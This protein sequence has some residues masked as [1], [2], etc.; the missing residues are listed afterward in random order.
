MASL[1]SRPESA[2]PLAAAICLFAASCAV[3]A[4]FADTE[5]PLPRRDAVR[6][7]A[8]EANLSYEAFQ[9][10]YAAT[11]TPVVLVGALERWPLRPGANASRDIESLCGARPLYPTCAVDGRRHG[12][13]V[14]VRSD[15]RGA[16]W[17]SMSEVPP[18]SLLTT[19]ADLMGAQASADSR[20]QYAA[21]AGP[22]RAQGSLHNGSELYLHDAPIDLLCPELLS[23]LRAPKF[24]PTDYRLHGG[25]AP[26]GAPCAEHARHG[27]EPHPSL[28]I[29]PASSETGLHRDSE[30]SRFWMAVLSGRKVYRLLSPTD[31][32]AL[33]RRRPTECDAA[34]RAWARS[35]GAAN[36]AGDLGDDDV[37]EACP[38]YDGDLWGTPSD[39]RG[40]A[41]T[42]RAPVARAGPTPPAEDNL[43]VWEA[44]VG[45]GDLIF[46]P[47]WWSHQARNPE[48]PTRPPILAPFGRCET[49]SRASR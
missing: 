7:V 18:T 49:S 35:A 45:A 11:G 48:R 30:A 44:D 34:L 36:L 22:R 46:I 8:R 3:A 6:R 5:W 43:V 27:A 19:L 39:L 4:F 33:R 23:R 40:D 10:A 32:A 29:A 9:R 2:S 13:S 31:S 42:L 16:A 38:G 26:A 15:T 37:V 28:F 25:S 12:G 20:R 24:F 47:H 1:T 21:A 14:K 41:A 17:G